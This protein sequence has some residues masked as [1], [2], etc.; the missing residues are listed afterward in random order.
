MSDLI[1]P[2]EIE[3]KDIDGETIKVIISRFPAITG[4]EIIAKYPLSS[5]PKVGDYGV[6]EETMLKL[7]SYV[8]VIKPTGNIRLVS[9]AL[10]DNHIPDGVSLYKIEFEMLK[11][12][13]DFL[14]KLGKSGFI[15]QLKAKIP[16][17]AQSILNQSLA[18]LLKKN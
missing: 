5:I 15:D 4:R 17:L 14:D 6:N 1:K 10:I 12:N 16:T 18:Q 2:K 11:Y 8:E 7:M 3:I 13:T 9:K